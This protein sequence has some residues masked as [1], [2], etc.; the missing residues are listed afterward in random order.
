MDKCCVVNVICEC[1]KNFRKLAL[2]FDIT[3]QI[4]M[5]LSESLNLLS[6]YEICTKVFH[7]IASSDRNKV[8]N[9]TY[10]HESLISLTNNLFQI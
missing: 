5:A 8:V 9:N 4:S 7:N 2:S 10:V 6:C 3:K 1:H